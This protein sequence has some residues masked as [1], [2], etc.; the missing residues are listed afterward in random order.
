MGARRA[1]AGPP[2]PKGAEGGGAGHGAGGMQ[3]AVSGERCQSERSSYWHSFWPGRP[4]R[5][6]TQ[7]ET[8][9]AAASGTPHLASTQALASRGKQ[10]LLRRLGGRRL[11]RASRA[12]GVAQ[13]W[14]KLSWRGTLSSPPKLCSLA[15]IPMSS[16]PLTY[17]VTLC[18]S[19]TLPGAQL[20][21]QL[22]GLHQ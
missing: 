4:L 7:T 6:E 5:L 16:L 12:G 21:H 1:S 14:S 9:A 8:R 20:H 15:R 10:S 22:N 17:R 3:G 19:L 13:D 18:K 2:S 11:D